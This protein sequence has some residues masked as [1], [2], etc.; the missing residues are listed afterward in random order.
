[1]EI[2]C[3]VQKSIKFCR[4]L[5]KVLH[6]FLLCRTEHN[7]KI[8]GFV[9]ELQEHGS[10]KDT[11]LQGPQASCPVYYDEACKYLE[12]RGWFFIVHQIGTQNEHLFCIGISLSQP[13]DRKILCSSLG[14]RK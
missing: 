9:L 3:S 6:L 10:G 5:A 13:L 11:F 2:A 7:R 8:D 4:I 14:D 1:M 12:T